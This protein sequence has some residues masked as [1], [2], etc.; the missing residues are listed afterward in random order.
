MAGETKHYCPI[1][2][3]HI[4]IR[5]DGNI[6][7][8]CSYRWEEVPKDFNLQYK[9]LF[10]SHPHMIEIRDKLRKD[11]PVAGCSRC[12]ES[13]QLTGKSMRTEYI[14]ESR[15]GFSEVPPAEPT[16]TYID[17][18]LSNACNNRCRMCS[19]ELST[20]WYSDSKKL[21]IE[22]P[23]GLIELDNNF[24]D[25]DFSKL[26]YI[27][28]IGGEPL[29]E[30]TK[31]IEILKKCKLDTLNVLITTNSTMRPGDELLSL[32]Q[33]CKKVRWNLSIDAY[34]EFNNFLRKGSKWDEVA[35]NL[36]WYYNM[37]PGCINVNGV[38][39]IYNSNNF[40]LLVDYIESKY[41]NI[42]IAFNMIDGHDWMHPKHLP[43]LYKQKII[44][45]LKQQSHPIVNRVIDAIKQQGDTKEFIAQDTKLN[46]L[47]TETWE[48]YNPE[49][50]AM[51]YEAGSK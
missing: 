32:L 47:R 39:S 5:P 16:L 43:E 50:Y 38:V 3:H 33:A 4:A 6:Q 8:C 13:E 2:F 42:R 29:M 36:D 35:A 11:K 27:K 49:L 25:I 31:F 48:A 51:I 30:Q 24:D 18:A 26:T 37:F 1:P 21:G 40:F 17:L 46:Q 44:D 28:L 9:D 7:P 45:I 22:I 15:L 23:R 14:Q 12:Y 20:N 34:G 41:K 19:Y 10:L